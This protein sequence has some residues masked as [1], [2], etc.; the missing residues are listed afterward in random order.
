MGTM[1]FLTTGMIID[2]KKIA[3]SIRENLK[4]DIKNFSRVLTITHFIGTDDPAVLSFVRIKQKVGSELRVNIEKVDVTQFN[5]SRLIQEIKNRKNKTDGIILQFPLPKEIDVKEAKNAIPIS[6]D[7]DSISDMAMN[8]FEKGISNVLPP[9]AG[10]IKEIID[11]YKIEIKGK[12]VLVVGAGILVGMPTKIL[13]NSLGGDVEIA[14]SEFGDLTP[15]TKRA[16]II[17]LG[18]GSP[19]LLMPEMIKDGA[20]V[21]D[22][23]TSEEGGKMIGDADPSCASKCSFFTPVPGGIGPIT[24]A[25][26]FK[27]LLTLV[28]ARQ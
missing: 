17:V 19:G 10:A 5:T 18:A 6:L 27:N 20:I 21:F 9:V 14:T 16:N 8:N 4:E 12:K 28:K 25:I 13:F 15:Y 26:L 7:I 11:E 3:L 23:G 24:V 2:G 22:A 1:P